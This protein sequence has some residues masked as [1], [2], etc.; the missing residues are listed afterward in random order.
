MSHRPA[1]ELT[2]G[3]AE[4]ARSPVGTG[5]LELIVRR[6]VADGREVREHAELDVDAGLVGDSWSTRGTPDP[7]R[8]L[9]LMNARA[10]A[11]VAGDR[12]RWPLAGD[13][14]YVDLHL[15]GVELPPGIRLAI[16]DTA[17]IEVTD[18]PHTGCAK[19]SAR[20]GVDALRV[21]NSPP[22]RALNL[23]G[24]NARVMIPGTI[25][26]GDKVAEVVEVA[27]SDRAGDAP[28]GHREDR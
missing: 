17:V 5:T 9:T 13:Q 27:V 15:G 28:I 7:D 6:P 16:G 10:A 18:K 12:E 3:L 1:E 23:R 14:L 22:G 24:I 2:A 26:V 20:F 25:R 21:V 4:V 8:Q 19:F 11:L